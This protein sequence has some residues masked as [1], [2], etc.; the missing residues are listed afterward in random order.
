[1]FQVEEPPHRDWR[2]IAR[3]LDDTEYIVEGL[4]PGRDYRF[5]VRAKTATG[6]VSEP[7]PATSL[8]TALGKGSN[9]LRMVD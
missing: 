8:Y 3:D 6:I 9:S 4:K 5:R 7:S 1:M 2:T